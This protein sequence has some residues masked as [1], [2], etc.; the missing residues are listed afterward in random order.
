[1]SHKLPSPKPHEGINVNAGMI[2]NGLL[3]VL[4]YDGAISRSN[5]RTFRICIAVRELGRT[6]SRIDP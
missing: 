3:K 1:M 4:D 6:A 5:L 2:S